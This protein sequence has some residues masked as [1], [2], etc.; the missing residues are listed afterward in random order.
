MGGILGKSAAEVEA[1]IAAIDKRVQR[2][3]VLDDLDEDALHRLRL[4][5]LPSRSVI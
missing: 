2:I 5:S 4:P 1:R 3:L